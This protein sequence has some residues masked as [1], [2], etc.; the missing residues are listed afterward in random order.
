MA[1]H[2]LPEWETTPPTKTS[3][4]RSSFWNR[5]SQP[6]TT[7]NPFLKTPQPAADH[8]S[9]FFTK[10]PR[11]QTQVFDKETGVPETAAETATTA[12]EITP[13]GNQ[14]RYCGRSRRTCIL[15][16]VAL[17]LLLALIIGLAAGLSKKYVNLNTFI[18][19][20]PI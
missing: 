9:T 19:H 13:R 10:S 2:E 11:T 1:N 3:T 14:R 20:G 5:L 12:E 8:K 16:S 7:G 4:S 6:F 17:I 18:F 15:I